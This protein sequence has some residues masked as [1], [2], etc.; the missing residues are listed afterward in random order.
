MAK[1]KTDEVNAEAST[2]KKDANGNEESDSGSEVEFVVEKVIDKRIRHGKVEYLLKWRGYESDDNTWEPKDNLQCP[3]LVEEYER[4]HQKP[5]VALGTKGKGKRIASEKKEPSKKRKVVSDA[6]ND[7]E[8]STNKGIKSVKIEEINDD[9][10]PLKEGWTADNILGA[11]EINGLIHF[12]IQWKEVDR[13]DLVSSK[14]ANE[15]WP[16]TVIKFYEE[17]VTWT[18]DGQ[19]E[20]AAS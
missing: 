19:S 12:L 17:R 4:T 13:A 5:K 11:T 20:V 10:D 1:S 6:A 9:V 16:Q 8:E 2:S 7:S 18:H 14:V 3:E 15:K